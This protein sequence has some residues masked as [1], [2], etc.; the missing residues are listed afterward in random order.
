MIFTFTQRRIHNA[1]QCLPTRAAIAAKEAGLD[2]ICLTEHDKIWKPEDAQAL[3][4]KHGIA[5][6][7]GIEITTKAGDIV[8]FGMEEEPKEMWTPELLKEKVDNAGGLAISA[9]PFRGFLLFGFGALQMDLG[10]AVK[11]PTFA[12]VHALEVC[13]S[14][15]TDDENNMAR[16]VAEELGLLKVGGSDA[17]KPEA[18]GTC[19]MVLDDTVRNESELVQAILSDRF[20]LERA[21]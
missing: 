21:K 9:H 12:C 3:S 10:Q 6:F 20:T 17:H 18:M 16:K 7:R 11:D 2:G 19:V 13:N 14:M 1:A 15:V 8:V 4:D 5:V